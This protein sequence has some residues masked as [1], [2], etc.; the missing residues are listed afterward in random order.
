[1]GPIQKP[2]SDLRQASRDFDWNDLRYVLAVAET[3]SLTKAAER[4]RTTQPTVSKRLDE[5]EH[6]LG[7]ALVKRSQTG[8]VLTEAGKSAVF[9]ARAIARSIGAIHHDVAMRDQEMAGDVSIACPDAL[10][11]Y[12]LAPAIAGFQRAQPSIG[13]HVR[14]RSDPASDLDFSIQFE[15]SKRMSDVAIQLGWAHYV[16]FSSEAYEAAHGQLKSRADALSH[17]MLSHFDYAPQAER[18]HPKAKSVRE[19]VDYMVL[20]DCSHFLV[21]AVVHGAGVAAMPSYIGQFEPSL[22]MVETGEHAR[23]RFWLVFDRERGELPRNREVIRWLQTVFD[24]HR[25]PWF[26]EDFIRP[27][28]FQAMI[29]G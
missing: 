8:V 21:Q 25:N 13:L 16:Q 15:E 2:K 10:A 18:W 23:L 5:L 12:F 29:D 28:D 7:T 11:T 22:R 19:L 6:R 9:H 1:M 4:L 27:D 17:K 14:G 24:P 20:S 3:G 26:R